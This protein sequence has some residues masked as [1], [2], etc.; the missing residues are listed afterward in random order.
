MER[1]ALTRLTK[2]ILR[3]TLSAHH[4][5]LGVEAR[6]NSNN[7][8]IR[9]IVILYLILT[10]ACGGMIILS[11][12]LGTFAQEA[13]LSVFSDAFKTLIGAAVGS[14]SVALSVAKSRESLDNGE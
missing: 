9:Q 1:A 14:L 4:K 3:S 6:C 13:A 2:V 10:I 7:M 11:D 5:F 12:F 8:S